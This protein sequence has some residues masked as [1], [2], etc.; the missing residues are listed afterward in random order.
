MLTP[1]T[2]QQ[3]F[4]QTRDMREPRSLAGEV[5]ALR[6]PA[7]RVPGLNTCA[8]G[9]RTG[10]RVLAAGGQVAEKRRAGWVLGGTHSTCGIVCA[11]DTDKEVGVNM[12]VDGVSTRA[13]LCVCVRVHACW[14][15]AKGP[16]T[17]P[18]NHEHPG[19]AAGTDTGHSGK[20]PKRE[21]GPPP[22]SGAAGE[23]VW[24][25]PRRACA[26]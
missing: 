3:H 20:G 17:S 14:L 8:C 6:A 5:A 10:S 16:R 21:C 15:A 9:Q 25:S 26:S 23:G 7:A 19:C 1:E 12:R 22:V 13:C 18:R 4:Y 2:G 24:G 11:A